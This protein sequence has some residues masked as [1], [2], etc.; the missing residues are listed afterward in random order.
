MA[1]RAGRGGG[2]VQGGDVLWVGGA[3]PRCW[4][5]PR[6]RCQGFLE[7]WSG[8]PCRSPAAFLNRKPGDRFE[9]FNICL[10]KNESVPGSHEVSLMVV[11]LRSPWIVRPVCGEIPSRWTRDVSFW[12]LRQ[13]ADL[14]G[15]SGLAT[16][17]AVCSGV[18]F[19]ARGPVQGSMLVTGFVH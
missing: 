8:H 19:C 18:W 17:H 3:F 1:G 12:R 9:C 2:T 10:G 16:L 5:E 11:S 6:A 15:S 4:A 13:T 14:V 7:R